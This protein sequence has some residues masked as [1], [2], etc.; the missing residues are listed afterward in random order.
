MTSQYVPVFTIP[1][2]LPADVR[3][4]RVCDILDIGEIEPR[5]RVTHLRTR[6]G[7]VYRLLDW[8]NPL[9]VLVIREHSGEPTTVKFRDVASLGVVEEVDAA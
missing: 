8:V 9:S 7:R 3:V 5:A 2:K 6:R 1:P 4:T